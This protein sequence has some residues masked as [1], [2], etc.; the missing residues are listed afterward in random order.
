[1]NQELKQRLIGAVVVTALAA[2]FIPM[3]FDDPVDNSSQSV[4]ELVIPATPVKSGE[5]SANKLPT[6]ANQVLN[7]PDSGSEA[8]VNTEE[9]AELTAKNPLSSDEPLGGEPEPEA[10]TEDGADQAVDEPDQPI[11]EPA[12]D[13]S[14]PS[15]DTDA[16]DEPGK[17]VKTKKTLQEAESS[18]KKPP[19]EEDIVATPEKSVKKTEASAT[20][21]TAKVKPLITETVNK[22]EKPVVKPAKS[23]SEFSRWTIQ[24]GTFSKKENAVALM[25]TLRKQGLPVTLEATRGGLYRLKVGP[26]LE[27]KRAVEMKAKLDNQKIQS[28]LIAE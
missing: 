26:V 10:D 2:I 8:V 13:G 5:E 7:A 17:P 15:L 28:I 9:E 20:K 23:S 19:L 11:D 24:A 21:Q 25:E 12:N 22:T 27:R 14:S 1:M 3:L 4:S 6:S 18:T 16:T